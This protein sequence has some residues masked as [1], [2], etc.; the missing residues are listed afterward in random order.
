MAAA[1][2]ATVDAALGRALEQ[3][4]VTVPL[5]EDSGACA[6]GRAGRAAPRVRP[7]PALAT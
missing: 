2:L 5:F 6:R 3:L 7:D 4:T 1:A